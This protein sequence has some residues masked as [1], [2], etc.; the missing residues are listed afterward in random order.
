M[1][2]PYHQHYFNARLGLAIDGESNT[3]QEVNLRSEPAGY[4][5]PFSSAYLAEA[6]LLLKETEARRRVNSSSARFWRIENPGRKNSMGRPVASRLCPGETTSPFVQPDSA[7][8]KRAG[9]L[10]NH[11]WVTPF[12][13][14]ERFPAGDYPNHN[15]GG[16]GLPR[17]T[18][19][20]RPVADRDVVLWFTLGQTHVPC[21]EDWPVMSWWWRSVSG[22][23]PMV[24]S[25]RIRPW[26]CRRQRRESCGCSRS[27]DWLTEFTNIQCL[28]APTIQAHPGHLEA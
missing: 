8:L 19:A 28:V 9:F 13:A 22:F 26:M 15:P 12:D 27:C 3:V 17:W 6:T 1:N 4:E 21:L 18:N 7:L 25:T 20:D 5:S 14:H 2:S 23:V 16:D 10:A 24:S 11:L